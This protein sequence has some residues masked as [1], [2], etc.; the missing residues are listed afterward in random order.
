MFYSRLER[1]GDLSSAIG[2]SDYKV[3]ESGERSAM[4]SVFF[5]DANLILRRFELLREDFE[6]IL[7]AK[8]V[9]KISRQIVACHRRPLWQRDSSRMIQGSPR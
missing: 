6:E 5:G 7:N 8:E 1:C 9:A 3:V 2:I 4:R